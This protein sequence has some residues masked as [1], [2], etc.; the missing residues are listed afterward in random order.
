MGRIIGIDFGL[1][2]TGIAVTDPLKI[3]ATGLTTIQTPVL[4]DFLKK[5][6]N[7]N[8]VETIVSGYPMNMD[9]TPA[10]IIPQIDKFIEILKKEF[11]LINIEK[12]D[13]RMTSRMAFQTMID[14]GIGK[15]KRR[16]KSLV[17][18]IS[19][20]IILQSYLEKTQK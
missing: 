6:I 4:M 1:K 18:K 16:D 3:I 7:E 2:R 10:E 8:E 12:M 15:M 11:P 20:T 14:A 13:E 19:A 17:D 9:N 5:Y